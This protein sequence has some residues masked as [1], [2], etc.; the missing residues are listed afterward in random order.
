MTNKEVYTY[1]TSD[2][3][4]NLSSLSDGEDQFSQLSTSALLAKGEIPNSHRRVADNYM[5]I[6]KIYGSP[7][8]QSRLDNAGKELLAKYDFNQL[9]YSTIKQVNQELVYLKKWSL[10]TNPL[11]KED[12]DAIIQIRANELKYLTACK[13]AQITNELYSGYLALERYFSDISKYN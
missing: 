11:L 6:K 3:V 13:Y 12:A 1:S 5:I 10:S 2:V 4:N 8:I 9:E 7:V